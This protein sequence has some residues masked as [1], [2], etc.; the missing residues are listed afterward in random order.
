MNGDTNTACL[1]YDGAC[2]LCRAEVNRLA[3]LSGNALQLQDIH[4]I[5]DGRRAMSVDT[6]HELTKV[7][8]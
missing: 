5:E 6:F 3:Q 7:V 1:F 2:P 8:A 4:D